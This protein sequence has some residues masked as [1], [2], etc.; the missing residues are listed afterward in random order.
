VNHSVAPVNE[1]N[2]AKRLILKHSVLGIGSLVHHAGLIS[3]SYGY[4]NKGK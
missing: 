3:K 4:P 1:L 2:A